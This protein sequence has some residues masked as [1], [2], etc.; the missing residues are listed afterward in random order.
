M[1]NPT[2]DLQDRLNPKHLLGIDDN[3]PDLPSDDDLKGR[4]EA[5][6]VPED[7]KSNPEK[8][9]PRGEKKYTFNLEYKDARGKIWT[10]QFTTKILNI[11]ERSQV[12]AMRS[13]LGAG[14]PLNSFD[15]M[16]AEVNL[17]ISHLAYSL[18]EKPDWAENLRTLEDP[19]IIQ[20]IFTEVDSHES[21]F[22]G[23]EAA[24]SAG[25]EKSG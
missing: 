19:G 15:A 25:Q 5:S 9:D 6:S 23:W 17:M 14:Q 12:G 20:A 4:V 24:Q 10:G 7:P 16:T 3:E 21:F 2:K 18:V 11:H 1:S 13:M 8:P 22:L